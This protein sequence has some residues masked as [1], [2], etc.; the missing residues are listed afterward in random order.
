MSML[1]PRIT[2]F[3]YPD[4]HQ[5]FDK[6]TGYI[7]NTFSA[8]GYFPMVDALHGRDPDWLHETFH[9]VQHHRF[10]YMTPMGFASSTADRIKDNTFSEPSFVVYYPDDPDLIV[11]WKHLLFYFEGM[12]GHRTPIVVDDTLRYF[13]GLE[14]V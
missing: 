2:V 3:H 9:K 5:V 13:L 6:P 7:L 14:K 8:Y 1:S 4:G 11:P 10:I 12:F